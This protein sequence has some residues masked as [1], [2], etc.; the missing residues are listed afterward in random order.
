MKKLQIAWVVGILLLSLQGFTQGYSYQKDAIDSGKTTIIDAEGT[1]IGYFTIDSWDKQRVNVYDIHGQLVNTIKID[2]LD[3]A[4]A[5]A[6]RPPLEYI[7][8]DRGQVTSI[9]VMDIMVKNKID[10]FDPDG[11][12]LG[13]YKK[14]TWTGEWEWN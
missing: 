5:E 2:V 7:K 11:K 12:L 3:R 10:V 9:K 13:Y 8:D 6:W 1:T 4:S 14:H